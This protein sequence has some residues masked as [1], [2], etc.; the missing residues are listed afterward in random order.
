MVLA[1]ITSTERKR[2]GTALSAAL[3]SLRAASESPKAN[4]LA[5]GA[6][7]TGRE[8]A[9]LRPCQLEKEKLPNS[10]MIISPNRKATISTP[11]RLITSTRAVKSYGNLWR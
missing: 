8:L 9:R 1:A 3:R 6:R 10:S 4:R 11:M 7:S 5:A 2:S